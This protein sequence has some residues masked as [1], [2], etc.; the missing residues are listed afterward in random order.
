[1]VVVEVDDIVM[2]VVSGDING[3]LRSTPLRRMMLL[4][5]HE[6]CWEMVVRGLLLLGTEVWDVVVRMGVVMLSIL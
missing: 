4:S 2:G 5:L 3:R 6:E 1:M